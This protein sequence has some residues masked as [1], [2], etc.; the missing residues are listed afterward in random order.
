MM[1]TLAMFTT[2]EWLTFYTFV[3]LND[4]EEEEK[5][6]IRESRKDFA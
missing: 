6:K 4:K 2:E 3:V 1:D 5:A